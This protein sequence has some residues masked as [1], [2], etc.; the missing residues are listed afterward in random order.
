MGTSD[1]EAVPAQLY[2]ASY[3]ASRLNEDDAREV[4]A[5]N[6]RTPLQ[7]LTAMAELPGSLVWQHREEKVP[8]C[9]TGVST[10]SLVPHV[11]CIGFLG[12]VELPQHMRPFLRVCKQYVATIRTEYDFMYNYVGTWH[13]K[14]LKWL[15]LLGFTIEPP[16]LGGIEQVYW[17]KVWMKGDR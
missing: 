16:E 15:K 5:L 6:H 4:W 14:G 11:G 17:H 8:L 9:M 12:A 13:K 7:A 3:L 1:Y 2:H 10:M